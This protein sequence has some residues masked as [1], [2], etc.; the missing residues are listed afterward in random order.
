MLPHATYLFQG[1][2]S[3][4][5]MG[6]GFDSTLIET[7]KVELLYITDLNVAGTAGCK[8]MWTPLKRDA[9]LMGTLAIR[10][11]GARP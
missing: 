8:E 2:P 11:H 6:P 5:H 9:E 3:I 7:A 1:Q 4:L 10:V